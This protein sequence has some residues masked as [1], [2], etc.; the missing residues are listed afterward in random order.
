MTTI[1]KYLGNIM[2]KFKEQLNINALFW[3][4]NNGMLAKILSKIN[5]LKVKVMLVKIHLKSLQ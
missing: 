2:N 1:V 4:L 5:G 3:P